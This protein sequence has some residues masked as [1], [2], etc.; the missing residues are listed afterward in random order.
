MLKPI[1]SQQNLLIILAA[2]AVMGNLV[3]DEVLPK[4]P[5][6]LLSQNNVG[7]IHA[8]NIDDVTSSNSKKWWFFIN[9]AVD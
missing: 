2:A 6:S 8:S 1:L 3:Q 9:K 4:L 5:E 7:Q